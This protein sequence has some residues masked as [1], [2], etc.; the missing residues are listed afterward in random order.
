MIHRSRRVEEDHHLG[1]A[2]VDELIAACYVPAC[3]V[4]RGLRCVALR[5]V[6]YFNLNHNNNTCPAYVRY[7]PP[8]S[9]LHHNMQPDHS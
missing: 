7:P 2:R 5:C 4:L 1:D 3:A 9:S 6:C 8:L